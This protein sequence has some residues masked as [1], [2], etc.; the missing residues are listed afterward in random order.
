MSGKFSELNCLR[1]SNFKAFTK[2]S[3][4]ASLRLRPLTLIYGFNN[5]GKSALLRSL[6]WWRDSWQHGQGQPLNLKSPALFGAGF[7]SL[8]TAG[9]QTPLEIAAEMSLPDGSDVALSW[10]L[11][12]LPEILDHVV[13]RFT[14]L[15]QD[16]PPLILEWLADTGTTRQYSVEMKGGD[17]GQVEVG[18]SGLLPSVPTPEWGS[19]FGSFPALPPVHWLG[20]RRAPPPR[21]FTLL[22]RVNELAPDGSGYAES[23][24]W[25][26]RFGS[27]GSPVRAVSDWFEIHLG[28]RFSLASNGSQISPVFAPKERP[29]AVFSAIESGQGLQEVLPVLALLHLPRSEPAVLAVEEPESHLHPRLHAALAVECVRTVQKQ[30]GT[31]IVLETH[32]ENILLAIQIEIA[33]GRLSP[34]DAVVHWVLTL[35]DGSATTQEITF[36]AQARPSRP[37]PA[38]VF[39]EDIAQSRRLLEAR[40][41]HGA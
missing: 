27:N 22:G 35:P 28:V 18:F 32:S 6:V 17:A 8:L 36:D 41:K 11:R 12:P 23:L 31:K 37:L 25:H 7:D 4:G 16:V 29:G 19:F 33:E 15:R 20:S 10:R 1:L 13:E 9:T 2:D 38:G 14:C 34:E 30:P 40:K 24:A 5:A 21:A 26:E 39:A 3:G